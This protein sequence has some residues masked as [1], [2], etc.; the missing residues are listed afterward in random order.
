[1]NHIPA[2]FPSCTY[3]ICMLGIYRFYYFDPSL[4]LVDERGL[5]VTPL[6]LETIY[7]LPRMIVYLFCNFKVP[8]VRKARG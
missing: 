3:V 4:P 2:K 5:L 1:M 7:H 8:T 6:P